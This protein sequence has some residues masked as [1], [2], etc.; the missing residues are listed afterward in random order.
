MNLYILNNADK[1]SLILGDE[2]CSG[3]ETSSAVCIFAS[4]LLK[5]NKL[6]ASFIFATHFHELVNFTEIV[7]Q[8]KQSD[9]KHLPAINKNGVLDFRKLG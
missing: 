8:E 5:L 9:I 3:T 4:V 1:N 6:K 7:A 2:V